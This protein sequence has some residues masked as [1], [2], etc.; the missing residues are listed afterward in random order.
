MGQYQLSQPGLGM[1]LGLILVD[2]GCH[3]I[4]SAPA[5][6]DATDEQVLHLTRAHAPLI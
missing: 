3:G 1:V 2:R 4:Q 5:G 6:P